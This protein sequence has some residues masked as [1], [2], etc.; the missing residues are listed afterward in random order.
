MNLVGYYYNKQARSQLFINHKNPEKLIKKRRNVLS[1]V[2]K[3]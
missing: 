3:S 1:I 2:L